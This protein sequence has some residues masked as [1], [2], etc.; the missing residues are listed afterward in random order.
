MANNPI[1]DPEVTG[2]ISNKLT[3]DLMKTL[4]EN[5]AKEL[6]LKAQELSARRLG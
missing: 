1:V 6:D 4:L 5:Q 3:P 2:N